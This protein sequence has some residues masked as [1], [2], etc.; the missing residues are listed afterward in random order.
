MISIVLGQKPEPAP[1]QNQAVKASLAKAKS[2]SEESRRSAD[3][4]IQSCEDTMRRHK[5]GKEETQTD[6]NSI[7]A[8]CRTFQLLVVHSYAT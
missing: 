4:A 3:L 1:S 5:A 2:L 6:Y 7:E 8:N